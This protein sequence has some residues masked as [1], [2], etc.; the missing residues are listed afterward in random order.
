[1][2]GFSLAFV[3]I[4]FFSFFLFILFSFINYKNRYKTS[5]DLRNHFP[6]ELNYES[7][8]KENL[9]GNIAATFLVIATIL[10]YV[11]F[12]EKHINGYYLFVMIAGIVNALISY[13]LIFVPLKMTKTHL[14]LLAINII[15]SFLIPFSLAFN[16]A[17]TY[18]SSNSGVA[19]AFTIINAV[20]CLFVFVLIMNPKLTN[21]AKM[22]EQK[23]SDGTTTYIRP[24]IFILA[25]TEWL[26]YFVS[27]ITLV[28]V[29]LTQ[30]FI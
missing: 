9:L 3:F 18:Q 23:N 6:Y 12:D 19:L 10:F 2:N 26:L 27:V 17:L 21:W 28:V 22:D 20:I 4:A 13:A 15:L 24:K 29:L 11:F 7:F 5:Y 25:F 1:M 16:S 14:A 8:F 30:L